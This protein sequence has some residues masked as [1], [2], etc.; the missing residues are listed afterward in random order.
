MR[1]LSSLCEGPALIVVDASTAI[2][3]NATGVADDV[4]R[5]LP[6]RVAILETVLSE[7]LSGRDRGRDDFERTRHL[8]SSELIA[9]AMLGDVGLQ[10][11]EGLV[12]GDARAT[13]DDGEA[14]TIAYAIE[15]NA[16]AVIDERKANR[17]CGERF[18]N[19]RLGNTLD[20]LSH[21]DV[22]SAL[23]TAPIADAIFNALLHARMRIPTPYLPWAVNLIGEE[24]AAL[25]NSLPRIVRRPAV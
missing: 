10:C 14:A 23:G 25:C 13:L 24:R 2:N 20:I 5:A 17:I 15:A 8:I 22:E 3:L 16:V 21:P 1:P 7:L 11:F 12:V 4:L 18:P 19:L 9:V 6:H